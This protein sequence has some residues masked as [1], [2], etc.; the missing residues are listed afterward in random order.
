MAGVAAAVD[1]VASRRDAASLK[2]LLQAAWGLVSELSAAEDRDEQ[3]LYMSPGYSEV[4]HLVRMLNDLTRAIDPRGRS[5]P[6]YCAR[7]LRDLCY[8]A[9]DSL[10]ALRPPPRGMF[11]SFRAA[12]NR[13]AVKKVNL[14]VAFKLG[15][16]RARAKAAS[17]R[18]REGQTEE[19][20]DE[21]VSRRPP[22]AVPCLVGLDGQRDRISEV[23]LS[24]EAEEKV[25]KAVAIVGD[26]GMG[27]TTLAHECSARSAQASTA[28]LG[29]RRR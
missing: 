9:E 1:A 17:K 18:L 4:A 22:P 26:D 5:A 11:S 10:D 19:E 25:L 20:E 6:G 13:W 24:R 28:W 3:R 2:S 21:E 14:R 12:R 27:K 7:A 23:L 16:L 8:D 29:S 15:V